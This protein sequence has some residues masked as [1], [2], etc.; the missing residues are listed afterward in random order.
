M[1]PAPF[2]QPALRTNVLPESTAVPLSSVTPVA[3]DRATRPPSEFRP[4]V[5]NTDALVDEP[6]VA[7]RQAHPARGFGVQLGAYPSRADAH[8]FL[9]QHA[10]AL[11]GYT[12]YMMP[13]K[14]RGNEVWHR[15][16]VGRFRE[17]RHAEAFRVGLPED[18]GDAAL[19]VSYR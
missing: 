9:M 7:L 6:N 13:V 12:V 18:L 15:I 17:K 16:R 14:L 10:R 1:R 2:P 8:A 19:V 5:A 3:S 4:D 11:K